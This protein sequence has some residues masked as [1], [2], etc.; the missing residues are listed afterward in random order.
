MYK[1]IIIVNAEVRETGKIIASS[2]ATEQM[3][4]A[5]RRAIASYS[6]SRVSVE[7]VANA[8]LRYPTNFERQHPLSEDDKLIYLPLTIDVPENFDFP[9]KEIFQACKDVKKRR[10]W[11]EQKLAYATSYGEEWLG[12]LWLPIVWTAKG[13][14]YGEVIG[15]GATPNFYEQPVDFGDRQRQPLYHLAYQ[16]LSSLSCPQAVYL[17]QFRLRGEEI[18]FDRLWPFPAAPALASLKAQQ[19]N[20][21]VCQWYCAIGHPILDLT[22]LP[23]N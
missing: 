3:V 7:V 1:A 10:Q 14:L 6:P 11:V 4:A 18:V 17:L 9:A 2:P 16:L 12:D 20:L 22:I 21:F 19:P 13:P 23:H 15:E 5:L 8:A